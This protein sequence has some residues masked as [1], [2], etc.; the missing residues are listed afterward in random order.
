MKR[1][2]DAQ[3]RIYRQNLEA[4]HI[5]TDQLFFWL[6]IAQWLFAIGL[7]LIVSPFGWAGRV[8]T[9]HVHLEAAIVLGGVINALPL[10]LVR[11]R[12]G[13]WVTR[14][15]VAV[16]Q[17]LWSALLIHVTGGRIETHFHVFGSLAFLAFYRD[18]RV[19]VTATL[20]VVADH[21]TRGFYWP[22]S[23]YGIANPEWWRFL[24]HA[25]WVV[26]ED[27]VL[28]LGCRRSLVEM[29]VV[30]TREATLEV[31]NVEIEDKVRERTAQLEVANR[32]LAA[33]MKTRL[34][35]EANLR[36]GQKLEAVGRL[37]S[38]VAHEINTPVQF[39][40]DSVHFLRDATTDLMRVVEKLQVVQRSVLHGT[41]SREAAVDAGEALDAA[42]LPY[43]L[44]NIPKAFDSTMDG[45]GRVA[46]IVSS[47]KEFAHPD[48]AEMLA[49][50]LNRG[51]ASTLV[52]ARNE[53]RLVADVETDLGALPAVTCH[54][55]DI[56]QV[57]LSIVVN[58]AHAIADTVKGTGGRG[59]ISVRTRQEEDDVVVAIGD[60]GG[61]I[62]D[63]IRDRIF[64]PFFTTKD[65]GRGT[66][67]GLAI[68]RSI[69]VD[70]H[71]GE[72]TVESDVGKGTTFFIRLPVAGHRR[73]SA[74]RQSAA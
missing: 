4:I 16:A 7:T 30:A 43:L 37:A 32:S 51:I 24:E 61:G 23:V 9:P 35:A 39:V 71:G 33:E 13:W 34:L 67:Q 50:D 49:F 17:V 3:D 28:V 69:V 47:M 5:E 12:P 20:V 59:R 68:A 31:V 41:P 53:Y 8:R 27:T 52:I 57:V 1:Y 72:L 58:A 63:G 55:G 25:A 66:G 14:H 46:T 60:T 45:L 15:A 22:E 29:G 48:A 10:A 74:A 36:Q 56:N 11:L 26:F 6:L 40:G 21:L 38:G 18:W 62:P 2:A 19:L 73:P 54:G 70:K 64:D 44:E 65:V 42:D